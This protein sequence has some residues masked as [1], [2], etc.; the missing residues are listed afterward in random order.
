LALNPTA[1]TSY[2]NLAD[3][4]MHAGRLAEAQA[5]CD[6][7]AARG[8]A[9]DEVAGLI[10]EL[11]VAR[12]DAA[13]LRRALSA[14]RG[15]PDERAILAVAAR[16]AYRRGEVRRGDELYGR[17]AELT[18]EQGLADPALG[19][20]AR[21]LADLGLEARAR[22]L[23]NGGA[24]D[25]DPADT[26]FLAAA[27]GD[28]RRLAATLDAELAAAPSNTLLRSVFAPEAR[29]MADL[30]QG[31]ANDAV[32]TLEAARW[33]QARSADVAYL[34]GRAYLMAGD[35]ARAA[36][37]FREILDH[38]GVDPASPLHSLA[39]LGLA[40]ALRAKG[41]VETARLAYAA[42][43]AEWRNAD[44]EIPARAEAR[45]EYAALTAPAT[46][47]TMANPA[48]RAARQEG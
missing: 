8:V 31:R 11:A 28:P 12:G 39:R 21:D 33:R 1:E 47:A 19:Q 5:V 43:L 13:G 41:D 44:L 20:R 36:A 45:A 35:G 29:A 46:P 37:E 27:V 16:D 7:A 23:M 26:A 30:R 15:K 3:P 17:A 22:V 9:G 48:A 18:R 38:P 40:R 6:A 34:R 32:S 24:A 14:Q 10:A 42:F 4:L 2:V 25:A